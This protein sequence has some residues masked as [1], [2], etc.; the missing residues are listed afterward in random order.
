MRIGRRL[1]LA[2]AGFALASASAAAHHS[3]AMFEMDKDVEYQGVVSEWKWQNPHVHFIIDIKPAPGVD[4]KQAGRWDVEGGSINIMTRQ[5]WTRASYKIGDP[6]R[7]V[8]HP[9]KDGSKGI[10]LFYAIRPDGTR[11]YHDIARPK[12]DVKK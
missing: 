7:I 11:L 12:D 3:F 4:A 2:M 9:M 8:G 5:G 10:S 1:G 6:I